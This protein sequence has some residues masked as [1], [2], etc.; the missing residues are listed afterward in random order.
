MSVVSE[1]FASIIVFGLTVSVSCGIQC[2][3]STVILKVVFVR[4]VPLFL[5]SVKQVRGMVPN[6]DWVASPWFNMFT[7]IECVTEE[8]RMKHIHLSI[9]Y[10]TQHRNYCEF[11]YKFLLREKKTY[12]FDCNF[13]SE[14]PNAPKTSWLIAHLIV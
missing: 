12:D 14:T 6:G 13:Y 2:V 8:A 1:K 7:F 3:R 11:C 5:M 10:K 9:I 4:A